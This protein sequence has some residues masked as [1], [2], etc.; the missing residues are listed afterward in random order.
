MANTISSTTFTHEA[1]ENVLQMNLESMTVAKRISEFKSGVKVIENPYT[2]AV[3]VTLNTPMTGGY[4]PADI[5]T[6]DDSL[7][8]TDEAIYSFHIR[9]FEE[10]FSDFDLGSKHLSIA[11]SKLAQAIDKDLFVQLAAGAS[12]TITVTGGFTAA[13]VIEEVSKLSAF[14]AGYENSLNGSYLIIDADQMPAFVEAGAL[15]GFNS[16]DSFLN[17]GFTG[18]DY[19]GHEIYVVR[20]TLTATTALAGIKGASTTGTGV[21]GVTL[22]EKGVSGKTGMEYAA[23]VYFKSALW[24]NA[25]DL[26]VK[27]DLAA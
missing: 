22:E 23:Y 6:V 3:A 26:V 24:H 15:S 11:S 14:L 1:K 7:T 10:V 19:M 17:N 27:Y 5:T 8:V 2:D 18:K 25:E 16:A 21:Q 4:T 13:N 12:N 9:N 20:G